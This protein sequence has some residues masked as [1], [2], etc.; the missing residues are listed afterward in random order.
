MSFTRVY[1]YGI[2]GGTTADTIGIDLGVCL[3]L[4]A[5]VVT[6]ALFAYVY[7]YG[8]AGHGN[9]SY[10]YDVYGVHPIFE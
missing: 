2:P 3:R 6:S 7:Y 8:S 5:N 1:R 4:S 9:A 10:S